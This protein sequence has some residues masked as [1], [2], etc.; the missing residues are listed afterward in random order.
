M[1]KSTKV[2]ISILLAGVVGTTGLIVT[3][4]MDDGTVVEEYVQRKAS[5]MAVLDGVCPNSSEKCVHETQLKDR[6]LCFTDDLSDDK[7]GE[8]DQYS[9]DEKLLQVIACCDVN[10]GTSVKCVTQGSVV[11]KGC[12]VAASKIT[13]CVSTGMQTSLED[14]L[15]E[16]CGTVVAPMDWG[17]CPHCLFDSKCNVLDKCL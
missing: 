5:R 8:I 3:T 13:A 11:P 4:T 6:C 17:R 2:A 10:K 15:G 7:T 16:R 12:T 1:D 9:A 14:Q